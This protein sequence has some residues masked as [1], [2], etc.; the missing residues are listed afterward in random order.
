MN[1]IDIENKLKPQ[2]A[3]LTKEGK[4]KENKLKAQFANLTKEGLKRKKSIKKKVHN[5]FLNRVDTELRV[6]KKKFFILLKKIIKKEQ[7]FY[8]NQLYVYYNKTPYNILHNIYIGYILYLLYTNT[9]YI[10]NINTYWKEI[11]KKYENIKKRDP[12]FHPNEMD[13]SKKL[14][15]RSKYIQILYFTLFVYLLIWAQDTL[16]SIPSLKLFFLEL[17]N[18]IMRIKKN[19]NQQ[20]LSL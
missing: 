20:K 13:I 12:D 9:D 19:Q 10:I 15:K 3:N 8:P 16:K 14:L 6:E 2:F 17:K 18:R 11:D 4:R 5:F 7:Y 1:I